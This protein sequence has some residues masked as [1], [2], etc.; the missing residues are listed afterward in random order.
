M[1][2]RTVLDV[3]TPVAPDAGVVDVTVGFVVSAATVV[4]LHDTGAAITLPAR[5]LAPLNVAV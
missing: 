1:T 5:S 4:K 3:A 2:A